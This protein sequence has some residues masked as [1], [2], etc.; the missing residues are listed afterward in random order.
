MRPIEEAD[1][2]ERDAELAA[3]AASKRHA[4]PVLAGYRDA[5]REVERLFRKAEGERPSYEVTTPDGV[6]HRVWRVAS[7]ET[8][9]DIR[10]LFAPKKLIVL[11]GTGRYEAMRA[12]AATLGEL[13]MYAAG[14]YGLACLVDLGDPALVSVAR[15]RV[16]ELDRAV[17]ANPSFIVE[18]IDRDRID[19]VLAADTV[20]HQPAMIA[21]I[22][23]DAYKLTLSPEVSP[24]ALGV[25]AH[26]ALA[27]YDPLI[28]DAL[29][30]GATVTR[31]LDAAQVRARGGLILRPLTVDQ[32]VHATDIG[33]MLPSGS[34]AFAPA[35]AP[36]GAFDVADAELV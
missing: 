23:G 26:R 10:K 2:A 3:I 21:V 33:E 1:P 25:Q 5:A 31:T 20:A 30:R 11:D 34:C 13:S 8:L 9:G 12:H 4:A 7:A 32:L 6:Q 24:T 16:V 19:T 18:K 27:K 15:H 35:G 28:A 22:G 36:L 14:N 29:T 17:L